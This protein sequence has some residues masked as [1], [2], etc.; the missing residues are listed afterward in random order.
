MYYLWPIVL[1]KQWDRPITFIYVN[2]MHILFTLLWI[3]F[4]CDFFFAFHFFLFI[5]SMYGVRIECT[6]LTLIAKLASIYRLI[7]AMRFFCVSKGLSNILVFKHVQSFNA[8]HWKNRSPMA[9]A[10]STMV[11]LWIVSI[12]SWIFDLGTM[13]T[14]AKRILLFFVLFVFVFC[15]FCFVSIRVNIYKWKGKACNVCT[16]QI[17]E[18]RHNNIVECILS[19]T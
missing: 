7:E 14:N 11:Y 16:C 6:G 1:Q 19:W 18:W 4:F 8:F 2:N 12:A 13:M 3:A 10:P 9:H 17:G 5:W 15:S